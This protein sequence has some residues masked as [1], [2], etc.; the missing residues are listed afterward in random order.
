MLNL[1]AH[2]STIRKNK[3]HVAKRMPLSSKMNMAAQ[4]IFAKLHLNKPQNVWNDVLQT[5]EAKEEM[6]GQRTAP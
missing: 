1:K 6:F 5:D 2:D 4:L 3:E